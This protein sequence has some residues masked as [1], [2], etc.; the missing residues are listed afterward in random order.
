[1]FYFHVRYQPGS[2]ISVAKLFQI[3]GEHPPVV[4]TLIEDASIKEKDYGD[5]DDRYEQTAVSF[6]LASNN[7]G[8][9]NEEMCA[10]VRELI[11]ELRESAPA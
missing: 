3:I 9:W 2:A 10:Q 5:A 7:H 11:D 4:L 8:A 6:P 1:V